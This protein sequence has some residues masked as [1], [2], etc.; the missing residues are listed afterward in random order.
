LI[1]DVG[2]VAGDGRMGEFLKKNLT[3]ADALGRLGMIA[4]MLQVGMAFVTVVIRGGAGDLIGFVLT[5]I[6]CI[7]FMVA[8]MIDPTKQE[9]QGR[10]TTRPD[11][12]YEQELDEPDVAGASRAGFDMDG[13]MTK[14][15][16]EPEPEPEP[17]PDLMRA[18]TREW[19]AERATFPEKLEL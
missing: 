9:G 8:R 5:Y 11:D 6:G 3:L 17:G 1:A 7:R 15:E 12:L 16:P 13:V 2:R 10:Y 18:Q 4:T 19:S 14:V